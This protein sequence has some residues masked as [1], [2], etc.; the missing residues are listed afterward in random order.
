MDIN[1]LNNVQQQEIISKMAGEYRDLIRLSY[2]SDEELK[3][4]ED[5]LELAISNCRLNDHL[6]Q[7]DEELALEI[8]LLEENDLVANNLKPNEENS[9][10]LISRNQENLDYFEAQY[11]NLNQALFTGNLSENSCLSKDKIHT[12]NSGQQSKGISNV[13]QFPGTEILDSKDLFTDGYKTFKF[14]ESIPNNQ[15]DLKK[16][17][18][19]FNHDITYIYHLMAGGIFLL[20]MMPGLCSIFNKTQLENTH[21]YQQSYV[22][23]SAELAPLDNASNTKI[24]HTNKNENQRAICNF[25]PLTSPQEM[26]EYYDSYLLLD[27][28][29]LSQQLQPLELKKQV[30]QLQKQAE[31]R[32]RQLEIEQRYAELEKI[33]AERQKSYDV[34]Q[35]WKD[36]AINSLEQSKKWLCLGRQVLTLSRLTL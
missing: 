5:I 27:E 20:A 29:V 18:K 16:K 4:I 6:N 22:I 26:Q 15:I 11:F 31:L 17:K 9:L 30:K 3:R 34:A 13:L 32:Q 33:Q 8:S 24:S 21:K 35:E 19:F 36:K 1:T 14:P 28:Q 10:E 2:P 12:E 23:K 7:M 25:D